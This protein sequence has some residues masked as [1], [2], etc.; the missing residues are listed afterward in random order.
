M[1][2]TDSGIPISLGTALLSIVLMCSV[3][4]GLGLGA[5]F[6]FGVQGTKD[7]YNHGSGLPSVAQSCAAAID[8]YK[9]R[10]ESERAYKAVLEARVTSYETFLAEAGV[11][12]TLPVE[13]LSRAKKK[14]A[15]VGP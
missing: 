5:G 13:S 1:E 15:V 3:C 8:A 14:L 2:K 9:G 10:L 11:E 12:P 4:L 7:G 6:Y